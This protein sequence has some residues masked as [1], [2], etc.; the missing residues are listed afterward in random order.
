[1]MWVILPLSGT[2]VTGICF[3]ISQ[4]DL[5]DA[6]SMSCDSLGDPERQANLIS[7]YWTVVSVVKYFIK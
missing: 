7:N 5:K 3:F 1:M 4:K 2:I 6:E